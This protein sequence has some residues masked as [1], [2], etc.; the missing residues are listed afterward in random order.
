MFLH[1]P[2]RSYE[3]HHHNI[4]NGNEFLQ[5][6][7]CYQ[8]SGCFL[9][10][11]SALS[12]ADSVHSTASNTELKSFFRVSR[13]RPFFIPLPGMVCVYLQQAGCFNELRSCLWN[14]PQLPD[15]SQ[16]T[17]TQ[18]KQP[19]ERSGCF[20]PPRLAAE[21]WSGSWFRR[22]AAFTHVTEQTPSIY[23]H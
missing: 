13:Q 17:I 5:P 21:I 12:R 4:C 8:I 9:N 11:S 18:P 6:G 16:R 23:Y 19:L 22:E 3:H 1:N 10:K 15:T 20:H 2:N 7:F 14:Y